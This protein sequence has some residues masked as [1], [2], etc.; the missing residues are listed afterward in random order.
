M[1]ELEVGLL[2]W[3]G[4]QATWQQDLLRRLAD[5]EVLTATDFRVYA[6]EARRIEFAKDAPWYTTPI[7]DAPMT[8]T[9]LSSAHLA[10]T[11]ADDDPVRIARIMHL[12]GS[13]DLAPGT[14]LV[15]NLDGLTVIAGKNGSGKSGYTRIL[16]Q[17][18]ATRDSEQVLPNAFSPT[19]VPKA[20]VSYQVGAS[21][22]AVDLS[23]ESGVSGLESPM[24][25]VRVFDARSARVQ[26]AGATEIAYIPSAL[27]VLAEYTRVLQEVSQVLESDARLEQL[28]SRE[29]PAFEQG[30]GLEVFEN[31]GNIDG[32]TALRA[33]QPLTEEEAI[34]LAEI[35]VKLRDLQSSDP[36]ALAVQA[37]Q[38][39]GQLRT[40]ARG[41]ESIADKLSHESIEL[42]VMLI[43]DVLAAQ[44]DVDAAR[45]V[46]N[47]ADTFPDTGGELWREM[48]IAAKK[49]ADGGDHHHDF[50]EEFAV[51]P[52]CAQA[53]DGPAHTRLQLFAH[54][55]N[56][57]AQTKL[58]EAR[59][60]LAAD[61]DALK[62]LPLDDLISQ[63]LVDLVATYDK[64]TGDSLLPRLADASRLRDALLADNTAQ[65]VAEPS[66]S[67]ELL[68]IVTKL[69]SA[70]RA[71]DENAD[72]LA[73]TDVSALAVARIEAR[74]DELILRRD[75]SSEREHI[76]EQHDRAIRLAR[77]DA[78]KSSCATTG[79]SRKNS[80]LSQSYVEKVCRQFETEATALGIDRVP[81]EL[82]FDGSA[83][84][85]SHIKVCLKGVPTVSV[86]QV[87]SE[88][89]QRVAAI[90]GF[91]ADLTESG[92][93]SS[94]VFDDPVSSL[95]QVYRVR[96]AQRLVA[97]A[98]VRQVLV[99]TH[100]F[101]FVQYLY[102]EKRIADKVKLAAGAV[103]APDLNY[104]HISRTA[105]GA[106]VPTTA[107]T[108]RHV[109]VK[110]RL[111]RL[112]D[113][114]QSAAVLY[115]NGDIEAYERDARDIVGAL[116][117]TWESFVEHD[118]LNGVVTRH[119]RGVQTQRLAKLADLTER[120]IARVDLGMT[121]HS[122]YMTG[123]AAPVNDGSP[124]Q[125]PAW[126]LA[127]IAALE[128][129]R[130]ELN[131]RR[132]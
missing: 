68:K 126:L 125:D 111:G 132:N 7:L 2:E 87:L 46:L 43:K 21:P 20:V 73:A 123:H 36:A 131:T 119:E 64:P 18:A 129:F 33:I 24:Q 35:P 52:L 120:D 58:A 92:D 1:S 101:T 90:A 112:K 85:V 28:Q 117:E 19:V 32:L 54:F 31:I 96:V 110:E 86:A 121:V 122:R 71:E 42:S 5:G 17:V 91:F 10:A 4:R 45:V 108:W 65:G 118:L 30:I 116:R 76:G 83:R 12:E 103:P 79:A 62:A 89:E 124:P 16:K 106:G 94:L 8:T 37:R 80:E 78:A 60:L 88:G 51:C 82:L 6:L 77:L 130:K 81:V 48:W 29:W 67:G 11:S 100:D 49:F 70:A 26:L 84:G 39:S 61:Q 107:E 114:Q 74:R 72:A 97:E 22:P 41:L 115:R 102:E 59:A 105:I 66:P 104:L 3:A 44:L 69:H 47:D 93:D 75:I 95:D 15:F 56:G 109:S 99:F 27:Q 53:L 50:P 113:R 38:R 127:E 57:E 63:D 13:N 40:L 98:E 14:E 9:A 25:R 128:D 55:M 34:E 23:W